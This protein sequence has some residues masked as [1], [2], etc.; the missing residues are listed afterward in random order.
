[1]T[2]EDDIQTAAHSVALV[3]QDVRR[4]GNDQ[5]VSDKLQQNLDRLLGVFERRAA[6][7]LGELYAHQAME[8]V[9]ISE[10]WR[11]CD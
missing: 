9:E 11:P 5:V 6:R 7:R 10:G 8:H 4:N 2:P 1:M 3:W